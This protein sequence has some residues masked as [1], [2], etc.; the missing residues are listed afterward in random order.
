MDSTDSWAKAADG[1]PDR[2]KTAASDRQV[3]IFIKPPAICLDKIELQAHFIAT[4][5]KAAR[6]M[7]STVQHG[8]A[9]SATARIDK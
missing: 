3:P 7:F 1:K 6:Q 9:Q 5:N 2:I 8:T 4:E